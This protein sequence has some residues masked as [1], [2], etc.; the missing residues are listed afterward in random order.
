MPV[1]RGRQLAP[2][3]LVAANATLLDS[4]AFQTFVRI[5]LL[6]RTRRQQAML[7]ALRAPQERRR[8]VLGAP[9]LRIAMYAPR[10]MVGPYR[11]PPR[12]TTARSVPLELTGQASVMRFA[13][14]A[15]S[16]RRHPAA[17]LLRNTM[18]HRTAICAS[19]ATEG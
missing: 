6:V 14:R 2:M 11:E 1:R 3:D 7:L 13:R 5:V 16:E 10:D 8:P 9:P 17:P 12:I 19:R 4:I 18:N 15:P